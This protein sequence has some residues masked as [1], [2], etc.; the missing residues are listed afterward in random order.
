MDR[1]D[2]NKEILIYV[3]S[4]TLMNPGKYHLL[5]GNHEDLRMNR[6]YGFEAEVIAFGGEKLMDEIIGFYERIPLNYFVHFNRKY[7]DKNE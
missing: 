4:L 6:R 2:F 3:I 7:S 1:G 5:R